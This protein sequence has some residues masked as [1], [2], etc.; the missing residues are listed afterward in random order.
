MPTG[1]N[2]G[3]PATT[4][5][6]SAIQKEAWVR[7]RIRDS[8]ID[9]LNALLKVFTDVGHGSEAFVYYSDDR[10]VDF[11]N[12]KFRLVDSD[13]QQF[14]FDTIKAL[15]EGVHKYISEFDRDRKYAERN[16]V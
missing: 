14:Y 5:D 11:R 12:Y 4:S 7:R 13:L 1:A 9:D 10:R 3:P 2:S 16:P 8:K 6:R 15:E